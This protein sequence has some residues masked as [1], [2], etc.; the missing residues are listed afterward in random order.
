[1]AQ[2]EEREV[3]QCI[4]DGDPAFKVMSETCFQYRMGASEDPA[5]PDV[6]IVQVSW[7][8]GYPETEFPDISLDCFLNRNMPEVLKQHIKA[9][10]TREICVEMGEALTFSIFSWVKDNCEQ[11]L[12]DG[13]EK[14]SLESPASVPDISALTVE[15]GAQATAE[16]EGSKKKDAAKGDQMTKAQKRKQ[17]DRV[18]EKGERPRGYDWVDVIRHLSQTGRQAGSES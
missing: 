6:F 17:W 13:R 4:Y 1:M 14:V 11:L 16:E 18:N 7:P 9:A 12:R 10:V 5:D 3:L 2:E 8:D 15:T